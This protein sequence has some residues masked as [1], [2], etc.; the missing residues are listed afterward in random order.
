MSLLNDLI[1][2]RS[3]STFQTIILLI[4]LGGQIV[5]FMTYAL[6]F[7]TMTQSG[8]SSERIFFYGVSLYLTAQLCLCIERAIAVYY[9]RTY[10]SYVSARITCFILVIVVSGNRWSSLKN[11]L[12]RTMMRKWMFDDVTLQVLLAALCGTLITSFPNAQNWPVLIFFCICASMCGMVSSLLLRFTD[13]NLD[14][15]R[16]MVSS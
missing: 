7:I 5:A 8:T 15:M 1:M 2:L 9:E 6:F 11:S 13:Y 12:K 4:T 3:Y 16:A 10:E 14:R